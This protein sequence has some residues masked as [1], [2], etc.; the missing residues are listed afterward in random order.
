MFINRL[1]EGCGLRLTAV[2]E[3]NTADFHSKVAG[4]YHPADKREISDFLEKN[5]M[6][7]SKYIVAEMFTFNGRPLSFDN[8]EIE[9]SVMGIF[10]SKPYEWMKVKV[11]RINLGKYG[12]AHLI[13]ADGDVQPFNRRNSFRV[14]VTSECYVKLRNEESL[15]KAA[16]KDISSV[17]IGLVIPKYLQIEPGD[18]ILIT[19]SDY[20]KIFKTKQTNSL[21]MTRAEKDLARFKKQ[22]SLIEAM[23]GGGSEEKGEKVKQKVEFIIK[24]VVVRVV[25]TIQKRTIGCKFLSIKEE[26]S[27]YENEKQ[28]EKRRAKS[29]PLKN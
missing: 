4:I 29:R 2:F 19:F 27:K 25:D 23:N 22:I 3:S 12:A 5:K 11:Y 18:N 8:D 26:L 9:C 21:P 15:S 28:M 1:T 24:A 10:E 13:L 14:S 20:L 7:F 16:V 6:R 17:G